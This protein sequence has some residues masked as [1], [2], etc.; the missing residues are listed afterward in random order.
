MISSFG[1]RNIIIRNIARNGNIVKKIFFTGLKLRV[2]GLL[3]SICILYL[4]FLFYADY[5]PL[6][7]IFVIVGL[8]SSVFYDLFES[9]AF[10]LEK[11]EFSG[12]IDFLRTLCWLTTILVIPEKYLTIQIIF[13]LYVFFYLLKSIVYFFSINK[14][15]IVKGFY[16]EKIVKADTFHLVKESFPFYYLALFT[17][18]SNQVPQLFLEYRSGVAQIGFFNIANKVLAPINLIIGTILTAVLPYL[19]RLYVNSYDAFIKSLKNIFIIVSLFCIAGAFGVMLFRKEF[20]MLLYGQKYVNSSLVLGYQV[21]Y[22]AVYAV[23]C[24]IG[25]TLT[26]IDKQKVLGRL[27]IVCTILQLPILWYGSQFGAQYLSAAFLIATALILIIHVFV[28]LKYLE[29]ISFL[30]YLKLILLFITG[31]VLS[32]LPVDLNLYNKIILFA[33]ASFLGGYFFFKKFRNRI[34]EIWAGK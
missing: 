27:S 4:Y 5:S 12:I 21:W 3:G 11:M 8:I 29:G 2:F 20:I 32:S 16:T 6:L 15:N 28:I 14:K 10:G 24:L 13:G 7:L 23:V 18:L 26:V 9:V 19:S 34:A 1:I 30:F 25:T 31:Y 33:S 22:V 17:L